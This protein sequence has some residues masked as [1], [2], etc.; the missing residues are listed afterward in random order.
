M[1]N[2]F[3]GRSE[4][5]P[6]LEWTTSG[7]DDSNWERAREGFGYDFDPDIAPPLPLAW[8][9]ADT[10]LNDMYGRYSTVYLR[11]QFEVANPDRLQSLELALDYEPELDTTMIG[12]NWA[13]W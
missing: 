8:L 9:L 4:P 2:L 13:P 7:F 5:S 10:G 12:L 11:K 1:W 3:R 6:G